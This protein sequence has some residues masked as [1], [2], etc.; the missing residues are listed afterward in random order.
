MAGRANLAPGEARQTLRR[1]RKRDEPRPRISP[2][3]RWLMRLA[4]ERETSPSTAA[5]K[6]SGTK[7]DARGTATTLAKGLRSGVLPKV[8]T[9]RGRLRACALMLTIIE[10]IRNLDGCQRGRVWARSPKSR[11]VSG[12][13]RSKI[14]STARVG[15]LERQV[16]KICGVPEQ[17]NKGC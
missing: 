10:P 13:V 3:V 11:L 8:L 17:C 5:R 9:T 12:P 15:E 4:K 2:L 14:P 6:P 1:V 7:S 16:E